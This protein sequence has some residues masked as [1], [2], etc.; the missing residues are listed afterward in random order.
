MTIGR[1]GGKK[2]DVTKD[3]F[4]KHPCRTSIVL[5][6]FPSV[7]LAAGQTE[8]VSFAPVHRVTRHRVTHDK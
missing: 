1:G 7:Q 5:F 3:D 6:F 2:I 4:G 8:R